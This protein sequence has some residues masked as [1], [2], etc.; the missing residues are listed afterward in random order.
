MVTHVK[1][2]ILGPTYSNCRYVSKLSYFVQCEINSSNRYL[3][4]GSSD[5][6]ATLAQK[7]DDRQF[8]LAKEEEEEEKNRTIK[9]EM[10]I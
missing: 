3:V 8:I 7:L 10:A 5:I 1:P 4:L 9:A 2:P 6:F